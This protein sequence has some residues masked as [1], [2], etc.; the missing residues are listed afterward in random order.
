MLLTDDD[1]SATTLASAIHIFGII[2]ILQII[3][4]NAFKAF[5]KPDLKVIYYISLL[6]FVVV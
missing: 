1:A 5:K 4:N 3:S 2:L 6:L